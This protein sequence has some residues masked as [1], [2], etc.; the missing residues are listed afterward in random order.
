MNSN[1]VLASAS[2]RRIEMLNKSGYR[3]E[4]VPAEIEEIINEELAIEYAIEELAY[5]KANSVFLSHQDKVVLA[6]DTVVV[7]DDIILGKPRDND[8]AK[9]MLK[10]LSGKTHRVITGVCVISKNKID[11]VHE[12]TLVTF[13]SLSDDQVEEYLIHDEAYDKAGSYAIQGFASKFVK[14]I[15]GDY[16]NVVGLPLSKV[17]LLLE[18]HGIKVAK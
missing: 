4:I 15:E 1:L 5:R 17:T 12:V 18:N 7:Y 8:D 9:A 6:A 16:H 10:L 13:H 11:K 2:L 3:F 14:T